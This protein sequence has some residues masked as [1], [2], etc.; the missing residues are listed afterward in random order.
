MAQPPDYGSYARKET[1]VFN[2]SRFI[3]KAV[4][5][6]LILAFIEVVIIYLVMYK[7]QEKKPIATTSK[8]S[9]P[10]IQTKPTILD[11]IKPTVAD[12]TSFLKKDTLL[13]V[14]P[15]I[16]D[17]PKAMVTTK[18][19]TIALLQST[20]K[21]TLQPTTDTIK[22]LPVAKQLSASKMQAI[23]N[24]IRKQKTKLNISSNCVQVRKTSTSNVTN[25]FKIAEYL[26][27]NGFIIGGR[28][29]V[30]GNVKGFKVNMNQSC[31][32][33]TIGTM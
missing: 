33:L 15:T 9:A 31:I 27:K 30:G 12:T 13:V 19:D 28:L 17:T 11:T 2:L 5:V 4:L 24:N 8:I 26:K 18:K 10:K 29:T 20:L 23:M 7:K 6:T 16:V 3:K 14:K 21:P 25:A 32:E 22:I 1:K